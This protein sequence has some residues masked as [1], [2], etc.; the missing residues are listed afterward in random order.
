MF[1]AEKSGRPAGGYQVS[2]IR[3]PV[4]GIGYQ[5]HV[6]VLGIRYWNQGLESFLESLL[7]SHEKLTRQFFLVVEAPVPAVP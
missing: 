5:V 4:L 7:A 2:S 1:F 3:Y 6:L